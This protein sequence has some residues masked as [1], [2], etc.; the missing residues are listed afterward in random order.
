MHK[1]TN[2]IYIYI[3]MNPNTKSIP[4]FAMNETKDI[5]DS[6][7]CTIR[8][9]HV[10]ILLTLIWEFYYNFTN[11]NYIQIFDFLCWNILPEVPEG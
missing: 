9:P 8:V 7:A 1:Y 6:V 10:M 2:H 3:Y 4:T 11:C 5:R